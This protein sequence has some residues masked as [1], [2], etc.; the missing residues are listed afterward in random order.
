ME[1]E[2]SALQKYANSKT[3]TGI[4]ESVDFL[5]CLFLALLVWKYIKACNIIRI[6][7]LYVVI[8]FNSYKVAYI[9]VFIINTGHVNTSVISSRIISCPISFTI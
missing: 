5:I 9:F 4:A 6:Q 8:P 7:P 1:H 3:S 2:L